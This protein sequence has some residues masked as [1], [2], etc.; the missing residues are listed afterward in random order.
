MSTFAGSLARIKGDVTRAVPA[1]LI[2]RVADALGL[3]GRERMLTPVVTTHLALRRALHGGTAISH[4]PHLAGLAFTPSAYCQAVARLPEAFFV[5][6]LAAVTGRLRRDRSADRWRGHRLVLIDG[7]GVSMP[8]TPALQT[9]FGQ[10]AVQAAGCGFPVAHLLA[11]FEARTG[12]L[13]KAVAAPQRTHDL[14]CTA[15]VHPELRPGDVLVGDRAFGSYAHIAACQ[16]QGVHVV[17][18]A[19]QRRHEHLRPTRST[20]RQLVY[21]KPESRPRGLPPEEYD[22][23]PCK[24]RVRE[25]RVRVRTPTRRVHHLV[26]VTTL[27]DHHRYPAR[28]IARIFEQRWRVEV[29]IRS[30]K[31]TLGL[32]ILRG[33]T[34]DGVRKEIHVFGIVY[35][36]VCRV[37]VA[38][39]D[40]QAVPVDRISFVDALRWL[41]VAK[42]GNTPPPLIVHPERPGRFEPRVKKRR[43][44]QFPFMRRP[45]AELKREIV[46]QLAA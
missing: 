27:L 30:L 41:R 25:V 40:R 8:D 11:A 26:L 32:D 23:L 16:R 4:L 46:K 45:R 35:N 42:P 21:V 18:R 13:L 43:P 1:S 39:A 9:A 28:E 7:T 44:K 19:H 15:E 2:Q 17:M 34:A 33:R 3:A 29:Q 10:P 5:H 12:Y 38:A 6:L 24:L 22:A 36:L 37:M 31:V 14:T 20:D